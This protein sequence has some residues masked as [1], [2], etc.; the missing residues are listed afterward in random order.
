M[1]D[2]ELKELRDELRRLGEDNAAMRREL[3]HLT[4]RQAILDC[5]YR[6]CHG[7]DR[8]D[9]AIIAS[10]YHPDAVDE[11]GNFTGYAREFVGWVNGLHDRSYGLHTHHITNHRCEIDGDVAHAES[12]VLYVLPHVKGRL[13][14]F[15][16]ARYIDRLERR[17]GEWRIAL[18]RIAFDWRFQASSEVDQETWPASPH[19]AVGTHDTSDLSY[20]RPLDVSPRGREIIDGKQP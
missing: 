18:R 3:A 8:H 15:G 5:V 9:E 4:E 11:R 6:Y 2:S 1:G 20:Q 17:D 7:V 19:I 13:I 10:A 14:N 16:S 12:Y